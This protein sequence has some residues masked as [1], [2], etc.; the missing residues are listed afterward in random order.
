MITYEEL[1]RIRSR[2]L[3]RKSRWFGIS[4]VEDVLRLLEEVD[5]CLPEYPS[6]LGVKT[7][8]DIFRDERYKT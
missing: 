2:T 5:D 6:S 4:P 7:F 1:E 8:M 3:T